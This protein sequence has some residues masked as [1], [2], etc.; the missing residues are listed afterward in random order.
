LE[1]LSNGSCAGSPGSRN[2]GFKAKGLLLRGCGFGGVATTQEFVGAGTG[3]HGVLGL[4]L[5]RTGC[6]DWGWGAQVVG[7]GAGVHGLLGLGLGA[8]RFGP[9]AS[10]AGLW[11]RPLCCRLVQRGFGAAVAGPMAVAAM[12]RSEPLSCRAW[13]FG[14][15]QARAIAPL[16]LS[17]KG[18]GCDCEAGVNTLALSAGFGLRGG[19]AGA[20]LSVWGFG[21]G[22]GSCGLWLRAVAARLDG[23]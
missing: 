19:E 7:A 5:G 3:A 8:H 2:C 16:G 18:G 15:S 10:A 22:R 6:W 13:S 21:R 14:E 4:G 12:L 1:S 17:I 9:M 11:S 23:C 20:Q